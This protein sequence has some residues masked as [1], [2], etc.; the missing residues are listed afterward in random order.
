VTIGKPS[1]YFLQGL[2]ARGSAPREKVSV[3]HTTGQAGERIAINP[4]DGSDSPAVSAGLSV[5]GLTKSFGPARVLDSVNL[6]VAAGQ[7]HA[8]IGQN[9]SG[10]STLVKI[11]SGIYQA[12]TGV[13]T[14]HGAVLSSP[15]RPAELRRAAMAF[16]HQDLGLVGD[17]SVIDNIRVGHHTSGRWTRRINRRADAREAQA[18]LDALHAPIKLTAPVGRLPSGQ[19]ALVAIARALQFADES[20]RILVFDEATQSMPRESIEEFYTTLR[21]LAREGAAILIVTHRLDEVIRLAER[22]T[23]LRDGFAVAE[24]LP[25]A[26]L[27]EAALNHLLL[28]RALEVSAALMRSDSPAQSGRRE[29][30]LATKALSGTL[31]RE[32]DL[33]VARGEILGITGPID[34]GHDELPYLLAGVA[35]GGGSVT[36][37]G[38]ELAA[39]KTG[40]AER[41]AHGLVL[42][43]QHRL[44]DGLAGELSAVEN[45][46]LPLV[47]QR[48]RRLLRSAWQ[49]RDFASAAQKF[50]LTPNAPHAAILS[51]SGGNQQKILLAKC[52]LE[53]P[54]VLV[55]H[56]PTQAV[57]VGAR[58]DI[59]RALRVAAS[60]DV[61]VV[62]C[63]IEAQDLALVCDRVLVLRQGRVA[64]ELVAPD[65]EAISSATYGTGADDEMRGK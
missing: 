54:A 17:L 59:L 32:L 21:S 49:L 26:S 29:T 48:G 10:K 56:E 44:E 46:T 38:R 33:T 30:T 7:I 14:A 50:G 19:R 53:R 5:R 61:A 55:A 18:A 27:D 3:D 41:R 64:R 35:P 52:L 16:V 60:D 63:S 28:G 34:S 45:L 51:Y 11:L 65:A 37:N 57:D 62:I 39:A 25:V 23:V 42:V 22:V 2:T 58:V 6:D 40:V 15:V 4:S 8:L 1:D 24:G 9:G 47:R 36:I 31:V 12:D 20:G 13:I 43:P